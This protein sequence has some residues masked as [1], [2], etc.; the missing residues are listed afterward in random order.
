MRVR[1][2]TQDGFVPDS[3]GT[4]ASISG[5]SCTN[6]DNTAATQAS[7]ARCPKNMIL[8]TG[9]T[10][11]RRTYDACVDQYEAYLVTVDDT[12]TETVH[13]FNVVPFLGVTY[14]ARVAA[15]VKP[16]VYM[17]GDASKAAC[18]AAGKRLCL[19]NEW[20]K[21]CRGTA[22]NI[23]PYG[24]TFIPRRCN[25][26]RSSNPVADVFRR[27]AVY[28]G[29]QMS[30]PRLDLLPNTVANTGSYTGCVSEFRGFDMHGNLDEW[31]DH[32]NPSGHGSFV[33]GFFVD[34]HLNGPGCTYTTTAHVTSWRDYSLGFRCCQDAAAAQQTADQTT[35]GQTTDQASADQTNTDQTNTDQA[36]T[37]QTNTDQTVTDQTTD[38]TGSAQG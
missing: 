10:E 26:E 20:R 16:H 22:N 25:V 27:A 29:V 1:F 30:D 36:T 17:S 37:D 31:V 12:N 33:G 3:S 32:I 21:A 34:G 6:G 4:G 2:G 13:L 15:G 8:V 19:M 23:F 7:A 9:V 38:Q 28:S 35:T 18:I 11:N 14:Q 5:G 24:P